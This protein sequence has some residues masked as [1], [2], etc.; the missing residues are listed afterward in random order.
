[1]TAAPAA[2]AAFAA[3]AASALLLL[4]GSP[5]GG[6]PPADVLPYRLA[7]GKPAFPS[8]TEVACYLWL[9]GGRLRLRV[10]GD[11]QPHRVSG[12]LRTNRDGIFEDILPM[13]ERTR[14]RQLRPDRILFDVREESIEEGFDVT[15]G[16]SFEQV[17]VDL[18][19][20]GARRPGQLRIGETKRSPAGLPA[21]LE[22]RDTESTWLERFG[23]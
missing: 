12:E 20:D 21:R 1:M 10:T 2:R 22:L 8:G 18:H 5:A 4:A 6:Q 19:V 16:G 15:L 23:F 13:G 3:V 9:Q 11:G 14:I 17:T 7:F